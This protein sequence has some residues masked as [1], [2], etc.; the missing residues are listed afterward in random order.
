[1]QLPN[2]AAKYRRGAARSFSGPEKAGHAAFTTFSENRN[3]EN[4]KID[5]AF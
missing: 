3:K 5:L 1:V 4:Q 2:F